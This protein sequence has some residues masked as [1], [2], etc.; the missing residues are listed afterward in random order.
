MLEVDRIYHS[1][2]FEMF[3]QI[4]SGSIDLAVCDGPYGVTTNQWD[5]ISNIRHYVIYELEPQIVVELKRR[6]DSLTEA[7]TRSLTSVFRKIG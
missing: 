7:E 2:A 4:D 5:R 6:N 3:P 1:D